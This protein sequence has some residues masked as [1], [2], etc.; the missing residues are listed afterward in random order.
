M[1]SKIMCISFRQLFITHP[2]SIHGSFRGESQFMGYLLD[3]E[4]FRLISW[5]ARLRY[6]SGPIIAESRE[7]REERNIRVVVLPEPASRNGIVW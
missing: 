2:V 1:F 4:P 3:S 7:E 6:L 5:A